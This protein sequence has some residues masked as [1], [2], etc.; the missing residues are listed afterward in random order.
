MGN[1]IK[2]IIFF[3]VLTFCL[4]LSLAKAEILSH[5]YSVEIL[6]PTKLKPL[7]KQENTNIVRLQNTFEKQSPLIVFEKINND[8]QKNISENKEE[9]KN[10]NFQDTENNKNI[11]LIDNIDVY[12][13]S[14]YSHYLII[15]PGSNQKLPDLSIIFNDIEEF[16]DKIPQSDYEKILPY[17]D[18]II[19]ASEKYKL[20]PALI[21]AVIKIESNFLPYA[22]SHKGAQ[23][24]MQIIPQ[25][26][27]Y[28]GLKDAN[29]PED[30][31]MAGVSYLKEQFDKFQSEE[32]A[33][34]AYNAG[35]YNVERYNG[36]PPFKETQNYVK[37]VIEYKNKFN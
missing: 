7:T 2:Y 36:I 35:P 9:L 24:L 5:T 4:F 37:K 13:L 11:N 32:L 28:L 14:S 27:K 29:D 8:E 3:T 30:N 18:I 25:T 10:K 12:S 22:M 6:E 16:E 20:N 17:Y 1:K 33:L 34:A 26:Q 31:I 15:N 19:R 23:G 21:I